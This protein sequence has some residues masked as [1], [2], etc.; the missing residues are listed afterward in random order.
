VHQ[1]WGWIAFQR[2]LR[3]GIRLHAVEANAHLLLALDLAADSPR[4]RA[5]TLE[6]L[7]RLQSSV[8]NHAI[9]LGWL[10]ERS[11]LPFA[12]ERAAVAHCLARARARFATNDPAGAA[13]LVDEC[14]KVDRYATLVLDR[15]ALYHLVARQYGE[16]ASR[17]AAL[18]PLAEKQGGED[19]KRNRLTVQ[20]GW[21]ASALGDGHPDEA[22]RHVAEADKLI[23]AGPPPRREGAYGRERLPADATV[24]YPLLLLGLRAQA[25]FQRG[26]LVEA[27]KAL[28]QRRDRLMK[29]FD[30][31][32]LDEYLL[33]AALADAQLALYAY[34][35]KQPDAALAHLERALGRWDEWSSRTNTP[36]EEL[37]LA[38]T[39]AYAE[40]H[41]H[42]GVPLAKMKRDLPKRLTTTYARLSE[43]RNPAWEP[44]RTRYELYLSLLD[45]RR[46]GR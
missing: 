4:H 26:E 41:I 28:T 12:D 45:L 39:A 31:G 30:D 13:T 33:D 15:S 19:G 43:L 46:Q 6:G 3:S 35:R 32:D 23:A 14:P 2:W 38:L 34:R 29:R 44:M 40:L 8:G 20:V 11:K 1:L 27:E 7:G 18:W 36:I 42:A 22:L 37:G 25:H 16:A 17:Y 24:D 9:A 21:A 10:E 5:A